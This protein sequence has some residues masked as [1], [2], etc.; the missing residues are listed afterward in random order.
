MT[1]PQKPDFLQSKK[2]SKRKTLD[3]TNVASPKKSDSEVLCTLKL[4]YVVYN[5]LEDQIKMPQPLYKLRQTEKL[6][7]PK[8]IWPNLKTFTRLETWLPGTPKR[9]GFT[10]WNIL[11][12]ELKIVQVIGK[13][14]LYYKLGY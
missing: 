9:F 10:I 12:L 6:C 14:K 8:K 11:F 4:F 3:H 7:S 13:L 5:E 1:I 2:K